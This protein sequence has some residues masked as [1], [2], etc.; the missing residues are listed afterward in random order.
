MFDKE[1]LTEYRPV[2]E[3][4]AKCADL[5]VEELKDYLQK[6]GLIYTCFGLPASKDISHTLCVYAIGLHC[7][8]DY[9]S[10]SVPKLKPENFWDSI[11]LFI[12]DEGALVKYE[13]Q[14]TRLEKINQLLTLGQ[15]WGGFDGKREYFSML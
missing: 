4:L 5:T 8:G 13:E 1:L 7:G 10:R 9:S 3:N 14:E 6:R 12:F 2:F 15:Y 11:F